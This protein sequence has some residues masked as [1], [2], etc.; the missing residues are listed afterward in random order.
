LLLKWQSG[1][2]RLQIVAYTALCTSRAQ[3]NPYSGWRG[4]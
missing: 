4:G 1:A 2:C 3:R